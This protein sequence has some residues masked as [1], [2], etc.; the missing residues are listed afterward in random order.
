MTIATIGGVGSHFLSVGL[1]NASLVAKRIFWEPM[2]RFAGT[3][4]ATE[5]TMGMVPEVPE[6]EPSSAAGGKWGRSASEQPVVKLRAT[7]RQ[8]T[9]RSR[10]A[11]EEASVDVLY[12]PVPEE[13]TLYHD[14]N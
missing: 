9:P 2:Q 1:L 3:E 10:A 13:N 6:M 12:V 11:L 5:V 8:E 14:P 4:S 7:A